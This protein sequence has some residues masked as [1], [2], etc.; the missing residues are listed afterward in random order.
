MADS[1]SL[2]LY[3]PRTADPEVV[4]LAGFLAGYAGRPRGLHPWRC[5]SPSTTSAIIPCRSIHRNFW[6]VSSSA[7]H[8]SRWRQQQPRAVLRPVAVRRVHPNEG[9]QTHVGRRAWCL[10]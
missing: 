9:R 1:T 6:S 3:N 2:I 7:P 10:R 8:P 4:D 5:V